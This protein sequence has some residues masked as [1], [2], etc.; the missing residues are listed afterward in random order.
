MS[1]TAI[2]MEDMGVG[3]YKPT[4]LAREKA[5]LSST[6]SQVSGSNEYPAPADGNS[7]CSIVDSPAGSRD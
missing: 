5:R 3:K 6:P 2:W 4:Q 1:R 7:S